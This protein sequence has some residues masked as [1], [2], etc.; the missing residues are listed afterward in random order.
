MS[1]HH[2]N[3][4]DHVFVCMYRSRMRTI[5]PAHPVYVMTWI[6]WIALAEPREGTDGLMAG[7]SRG[8][9]QTVLYIGVADSF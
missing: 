2:N 7:R 6:P 9:S 4:W 1:S 5:L 3:Q 8:T